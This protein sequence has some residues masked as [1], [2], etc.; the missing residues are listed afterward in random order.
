MNITQQQINE[1]AARIDPHGHDIR[2]AANK[3]DGLC[4]IIMSAYRMLYDKTESGALGVLNGLM[5]DYEERVAKTIPYK[6]VKTFID[7]AYS[8]CQHYRGDTIGRVIHYITVICGLIIGER[9][10]V[11]N[12]KVTYPTSSDPFAVYT[13]DKGY[14]ALI[15]RDAQWNARRDRLLK[16]IQEERHPVRFTRAGIELLR[17]IIPKKG[18]AL[19][20]EGCDHL[21]DTIDRFE[22]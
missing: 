17:R 20:E 22:Y 5:D 18:D 10:Q 21:T 14:P 13:H 4:K 16:P 9:V 7:R 15:F 11:G 12:G 6:E 8:N 1:L 19:W 2:K 3:G